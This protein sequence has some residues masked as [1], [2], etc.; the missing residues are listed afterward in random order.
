MNSWQPEWRKIKRGRKYRFLKIGWVDNIITSHHHISRLEILFAAQSQSMKLES[1]I[2]LRK[3]NRWVSSSLSSLPLFFF[4]S[5]PLQTNKSPLP[6][7]NS[8]HPHRT[9]PSSYTNCLRS[10]TLGRG[11]VC[12]HQYKDLV[13]VIWM[14][15]VFPLPHRVA[16]V[17][18]AIPSDGRCFS[19]GARMPSRKDQ[20]Q[21]KPHGGL[22]SHSHS[23][24]CSAHLN[25][26][27]EVDGLRQPAY[28][29]CVWTIP[30]LEL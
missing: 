28:I 4:L 15:P 11:P 30:L 7:R 13:P 17:S 6:N 9:R 12:K 18:D 1:R 27:A 20:I 10:S 29:Y 8:R 25:H 3:F 24:K 21:G 22:T 23:A 16:A 14:L 5:L 2:L 19:T 26:C